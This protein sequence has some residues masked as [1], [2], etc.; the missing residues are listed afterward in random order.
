[1]IGPVRN[2]IREQCNSRLRQIKADGCFFI[3][4][5]A[6]YEEGKPDTELFGRN[7]IIGYAAAAKAYTDIQ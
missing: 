2:E 3:W 6:E 4:T 5:N 1:M 7:R